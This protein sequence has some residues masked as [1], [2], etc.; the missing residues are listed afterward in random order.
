MDSLKSKEKSAGEFYSLFLGNLQF[1]SL[2]G[3]SGKLCA[4]KFYLQ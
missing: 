3:A 1:V 4:D 2:G